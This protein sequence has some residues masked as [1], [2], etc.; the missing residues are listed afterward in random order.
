MSSN[1]EIEMIDLSQNKLKIKE[2][3]NDNDEK[4]EDI[5]EDT[6]Y[7]FINSLKIDEEY[8]FINSLKIEM[9]NLCP[10]NEYQHVNPQSPF[11]GIIGDGK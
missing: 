4:I 2:N 3:D 6:E 7:Y 5:N 10:D 11:T 1:S 9:E 8:Y